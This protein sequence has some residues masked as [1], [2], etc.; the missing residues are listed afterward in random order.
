MQ[1]EE[2]LLQTEGIKL[3]EW[4]HQVKR[5][6]PWRKTRD[7]YP[8][9]ISETMLQQTRVDAVIPYF[10]RFLQT[11]PTPE[12]LVEAEEEEVVAV[13]QGLGYYSRARNLQAGVK[14]WLTEYGKNLP[15]ERKKLEKLRGIGPYTAGALLSI[16]YDL[17]EAAVDG[18]VFRV[19][20]RYREIADE[21]QLPKTRGKVAGIVLKMMPPGKAGDFNQ[22]LMELGSSLCSP[23]SPRCSLCPLRES[24]KAYQKG[25]VLD[26]PKKKASK[27]PKPVHVFAGVLFSE[28]GKILLRKRKSRGLLA[29][30]WEFPS[31]ET[32][33]VEEGTDALKDLFQKA[34]FDVETAELICGVEHIFSHRRW[35]L[36]AYKMHQK[37]VNV[38]IPSDWNWHC[39]KSPDDILWAGPHR[40]VADYLLNLDGSSARKNG[41]EKE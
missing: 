41:E 33:Q 17:P 8:I 38:L 22:A 3:L 18:N 26:Y 12:S 36:L 28:E 29:G 2:L 30:M 32:S 37:N 25:T 15:K 1:G 11:F 24:C 39:W 13:W 40:K 21:I 19:I 14:E 10:E 34:G 4:Y 31:V 27:P 6:L 35:N 16:V 23:T 9:W 5:D 20:T 7:P